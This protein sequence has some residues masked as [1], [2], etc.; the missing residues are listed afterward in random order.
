MKSIKFSVDYEKLPPYWIG[1]EATLIAVYPITVELLK[2]KFPAFIEFDTK[3]RNEDQYYKLNFQD[4]LILIFLHHKS[5]RIFPTIRRAY[6]EK[7]NYYQ[8]SV[9]ETFIMKKIGEDLKL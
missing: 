4:A 1:T 6:F 8:H 5:G 9:G 2:N 7:N 3:I